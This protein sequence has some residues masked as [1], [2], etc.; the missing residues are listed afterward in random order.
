MRGEDERFTAYVSARS[1]WPRRMSYLLCHDWDRADD[2]V[3]PAVMRL[4]AHWRRAEK[5][6]T[7][8]G[9]PVRSWCGPSSPSR[10]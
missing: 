8:M 7:L 1:G 4:Y 6:E 10:A 5:V 9:M 2:L 3:Q